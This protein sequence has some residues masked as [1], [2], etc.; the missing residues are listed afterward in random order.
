MR[1]QPCKSS[2]GEDSCVGCLVSLVALEGVYGG[3]VEEVGE[4]GGGPGV[5]VIRRA[6]MCHQTNWTL[7][8][9]PA[10]SCNRREGVKAYLCIGI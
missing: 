10:V 5:V 8:F 2:R 7:G 9:L 1:V 4:L 6:K 3:T